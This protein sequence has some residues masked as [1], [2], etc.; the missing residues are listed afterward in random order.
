MY[1]AAKFL[2]RRCHLGQTG[3]VVTAFIRSFER[4]PR[5]PQIVGP[6]ESGH[7]KQNATVEITTSTL[8]L[9]GARAAMIVSA[10]LLTIAGPA[11]AAQFMGLGHLPGGDFQS[12]AR[13]VS[14]DA[15]VVVGYSVNALGE[16]AF[17]WTDGM[18]MVGLGYLPGRK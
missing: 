5:C 7:Y 12:R 4:K 15:S 1:P 18:G 9:R 2:A 11:R 3:L 14:A 8:S 10:L 13:D 16:E 6:D 17:R